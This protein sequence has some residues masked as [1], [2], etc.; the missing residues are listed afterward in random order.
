M[1]KKIKRSHVIIIGAGYSLK[2]YNEKIKKFIEEN[3]LITV[4]INNI[5][6]M[7]VPDYHFWGSGHRWKRYGC[8]VN[9][10]STLIFSPGFSKKLINKYWKNSYIIYKTDDRLP[11]FDK[12]EYKTIYHCFRNTVMTAI[13]WAYRNKAS[14]I[15][16][17]GMDG[18]TYYS[19]KKLEMK[20]YAQHCYGE[21]Y[22]DGQTYKFGR[23]KD[24]NNYE[25]LKLLYRYG[26]KKYGFGFKILTPTIYSKFYES[27]VLNIKEKYK[28]KPLSI[29]EKK[30][31]KNWQKNRIIKGSKY[32]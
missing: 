4:G 23:R 32:W 3:N 7:I 29:K 25:I 26:K 20:E 8:F 19:E 30:T 31:M 10:K 18:Y 22:T 5:S 2:K 14:K 28:G 11:G 24:I 9:E 27:K 16:I 6:N 13:F 12:K 17:V 15:S 1:K 21:G